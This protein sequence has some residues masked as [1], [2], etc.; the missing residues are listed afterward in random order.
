M[1]TNIKLLKWRRE[2][3][4]YYMLRLEGFVGKSKKETMESWL[5]ENCSFNW[6]LYYA[7][8]KRSYCAFENETDAMAFKLRW[9]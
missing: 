8:Y 2:K 6:D 7:P 4:E 9:L 3:R 1:K 5:S